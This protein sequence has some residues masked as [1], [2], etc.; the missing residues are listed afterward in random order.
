[1]AN[2]GMGDLLTA[3]RNP[4]PQVPGRNQDLDLESQA[5]LW[6]VWFLAVRRGNETLAR[7][8]M[9]G[10]VFG[11]FRKAGELIGMILRQLK[12]V[13]CNKIHR[14]QCMI[15]MYQADHAMLVSR[16]FDYG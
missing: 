14:N 2:E 9:D 8:E 11:W 6:P 13:K 4:M 1:M 12:N 15:Y 16:C 5:P 3:A 10:L 7:V